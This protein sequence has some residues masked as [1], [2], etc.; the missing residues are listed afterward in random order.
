MGKVIQT[1]I[2]RPMLNLVVG[3]DFINILCKYFES[4]SIFLLG[5]GH[6]KLAFP[7]LKFLLGI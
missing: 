1:R 3:L 4:V 5:K 2:V 6:G 7:C